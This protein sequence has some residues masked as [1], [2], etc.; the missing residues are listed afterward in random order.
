M[1]KPSADL[2]ILVALSGVD[3]P[4]ARPPIFTGVFDAIHFSMLVIPLALVIAQIT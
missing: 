3:A 4:G 1:G 2:K